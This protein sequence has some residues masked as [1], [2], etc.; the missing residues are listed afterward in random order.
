MPAKHAQPLGNLGIVVLV[1][2]LASIAG[3]A[4]GVIDVYRFWK[5][6]EPAVNGAPPSP[7]VSKA[8]GGDGAM[9]GS[10]SAVD[11]TTARLKSAVEL[12]GTLH[13]QAMRELNPAPLYRI[14]ANEALKQ[15]VTNMEEL[16]NAGTYAL[17]QRHSIAYGPITITP[18]G[19]RAE[20]QATPVWELRIFS[21]SNHQCLLHL[22]ARDIPQKLYLEQRSGE[23]MITAVEF[24]Q[25]GEEEPVPC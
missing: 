8:A 24:E 4:T 13:A 11:V 19:D 1:G 20:V 17:A 21:I 15:Q 10:S 18:Q 14:F 2:F 3:I 12:A 6:E 7:L 5:G 9:Q 22:P 25:M 23:W 16:R